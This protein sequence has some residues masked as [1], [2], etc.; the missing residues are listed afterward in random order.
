MLLFLHQMSALSSSSCD[1]ID[2]YD[3]AH[4]QDNSCCDIILISLQHALIQNMYHEAYSW[5]LFVSEIVSIQTTINY[6]NH[7]KKLSSAAFFEYS[8]SMKLSFNH[9]ILDVVDH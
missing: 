6:I 8:E 5:N 9:H 1:E 2:S 4:S 3:F 7:I